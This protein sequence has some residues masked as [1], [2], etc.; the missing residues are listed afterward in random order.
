MI[1]LDVVSINIG[2]LKSI[3]RRQLLFN[4]CRDG[5]FGVVGLQEVA[6]HICPII[7]SRYHLFTNLG[8][9]KNGTAILLKHGLNHSRLLLDPDGRVISIYLR[10]SFTFI[11]IYAPSGDQ[12]KD[13]RDNFLRCTIPAYALNSR[14]P[15][16]LIS[17][18]NCV[19][20]IQDITKTTSR[21]YLPKL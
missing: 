14:L 15:L 20:D 18:F 8:P 5:D 21:K 7:E 16:V 13:E 17:D 6:F 9:N 4:F 11:N 1:H 2:G 19:D 12:A 3:E 10:L